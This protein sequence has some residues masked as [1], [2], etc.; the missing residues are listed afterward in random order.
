MGFVWA[1]TVQKNE[2]GAAL[3]LCFRGR[4]F[5]KCGRGF[6]VVADWPESQEMG[7]ESSLLPGRPEPTA[8]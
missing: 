8:E 3:E 7:C 5:L 2:N 4:K 6:K 1:V